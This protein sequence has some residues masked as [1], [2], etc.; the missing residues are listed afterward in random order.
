MAAAVADEE[1]TT[2]P[3]HPG[4]TEALRPAPQAGAL[5]AG[6]SAAPG[7]MCPWTPRLVRRRAGDIERCGEQRELVGRAH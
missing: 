6:Q 4:Q 2:P 7:R 3:L 1:R 5:R